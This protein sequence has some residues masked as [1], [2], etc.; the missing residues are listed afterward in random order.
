M[1]LSTIFDAYL[2]FGLISTAHWGAMALCRSMGIKPR[3]IPH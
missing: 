1:L 2:F 3:G